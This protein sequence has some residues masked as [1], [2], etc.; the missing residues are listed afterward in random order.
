MRSRSAC[1]VPSAA[2]VTRPSLFWAAAQGTPAPVVAVAMHADEALGFPEA[3]HGIR[4]KRIRRIDARQLLAMQLLER[5]R[6]GFPISTEKFYTVA[7]RSSPQRNPTEQLSC[8]I[9][10]DRSIENKDVTGG[11]NGQFASVML[12]SVIAQALVKDNFSRAFRL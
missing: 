5:R 6:G 1:G 4:A 9:W 8:G 11:Y 3:R 12:H 10:L 2:G 7:D